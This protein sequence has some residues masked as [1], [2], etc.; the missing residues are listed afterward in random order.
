MTYFNIILSRNC[1][2]MMAK[3]DK[4][5]DILKKIKTKT[6]LFFYIILINVIYVILTKIMTK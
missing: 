4:Y 1:Y 5:I 3:I 2:K 6:M